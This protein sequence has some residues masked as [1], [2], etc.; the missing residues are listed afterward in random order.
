MRALDRALEAEHDLAKVVG[1]H[2][3]SIIAPAADPGVIHLR[4]A[5]GVPLL[6]EWMPAFDV[7]TEHAIDVA[8]SVE[9]TYQVAR[10]S[11][12]S[13]PLLVRVL[14]GL[15]AIPALAARMGSARRAGATAAAAQ[16]TGPGG[17]PFTLLAEAP[18][19]KFVLGLAGRFW[20]PS[21]GVV[22]SLP[23]AFRSGPP[24]GRA[25]AVWNFRV[26][27]RAHGCR[28]TTA[29]RV[30]CADAATRTH[31]L[32][33]WRVVRFGSGLIRRSMLRRIRRE[34]ERRL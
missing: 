2:G 3:T 26:E 28:L 32:R 8:A 29:T 30:L 4:Y 13:T 14:V 9:R 20:T 34:A 27:P 22:P 12:L 23:E 18:G 19:S 21:G 7:A 17:L 1:S 16:V 11:Q 25:H 31:F 33:Y 5:R 10:S 24:A 15:R 6:D